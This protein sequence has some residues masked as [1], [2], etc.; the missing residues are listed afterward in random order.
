M[1]KLLEICKTGT[2]IVIVSH[3]IAQIEKLCSR[4]IWINNGL[5][6]MDGIPRDVHLYY[7]DYL[8]KKINQELQ[9]T[10]KDTELQKKDDIENPPN[11]SKE[12]WVH[13]V[14]MLDKNGEIMSV[15]ETGD[16]VTIHIKYSA[17][18][19]GVKAIVSAGVVRE[20]GVHCFSTNTSIAKMHNISLHQNGTIDF[21]M[22]KLNFL[23]GYYYLDVALS[24]LDGNRL[25]DY[26]SNACVFQMI[27]RDGST[28]LIRM[29]GQ[30]VIE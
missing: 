21:V 3:S 17:K 14:E 23:S 27:S 15:F 30:W 1:N 20:D 12:A 2:T 9:T 18:Q 4:S 10:K 24:Y 11:A 29:N 8:G 7:Q 5:V 22:E 25:Y 16:K 28:G 26:V 13:S 19:E 6:Q